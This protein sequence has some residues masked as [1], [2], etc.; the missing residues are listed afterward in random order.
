MSKRAPSGVTVPVRR[1]TRP[2]TASRTRATVA[3]ATSVVTGVGRPNESAV[4]A[5]TPHTSEARVRVTRSAGPSRAALD[6]DR[7]RASAASR[8]TAQARPTTQPG[9]PSPT[10]PASA[11]SS[12][13]WATSPIT[14]PG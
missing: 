3:S 2:S 1:A 10:V 8:A 6:R 9:A 5:A 7:P 13:A 14:G 11:T 12:A 4:S